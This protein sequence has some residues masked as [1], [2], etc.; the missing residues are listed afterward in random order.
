M[1]L[2]DTGVLSWR[3]EGRET[4]GQFEGEGHGSEISFF[5][6][7][8]APG[9]GPRLHRHPYSETFCVQAGRARFEVDG[10]AVEAGAGDVVVAPAGSPHRFRAIGDERLRLV[11]IQ[12]A[13]KMET[14]WLEEAR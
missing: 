3:Y 5:V 7:D 6:V 11:A 14:T 8:M 1:Q 2:D 13:P 12:A 4:A 10:R 9:E